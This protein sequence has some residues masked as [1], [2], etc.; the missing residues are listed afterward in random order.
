MGAAHVCL[1]GHCLHRLDAGRAGL[2]EEDVRHPG[3]D[4]LAEQRRAVVRPP[5]DQRDARPALRRQLRD[6]GPE[7]HARGLRLRSPRG[8]VLAAGAA[9][10]GAEEP[11]LHHV[12]E[13]GAGDL[14]RQQLLAVVP[15][16]GS[17]QATSAPL[18][19]VAG[20]T[21]CARTHP[22][23]GRARADHRVAARRRRGHGAPPSGARGQPQR[24]QQWG[25]A[26]AEPEGLGGAHARGEGC[27]VHWLGAREG[28]AASQRKWWR[29]LVAGRARPSTTHEQA[30]AQQAAC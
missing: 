11:R 30:Q 19:S 26:V 9:G 17:R 3:R 8:K 6:G 2:L 14:A 23:V 5:C 13:G 1:G 24:P 21:G 29:R 16:C 27:G 7:A 22:A 20:V 25:A 18:R 15:A 12:R 4:R 28:P 10:P